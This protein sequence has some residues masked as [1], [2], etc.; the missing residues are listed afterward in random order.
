DQVAR[1]EWC[2]AVGEGQGQGHGG[3][4]RHDPAQADPGNQEEG[5]PGGNGIALAQAGAEPA[6]N[7]GGGE[8]P[9][10]SKGDDGGSDEGGI[11]D[12]LRQG[13]AE[14]SQPK[15][16]QG[17]LKS[18]EDEHDAVEQEDQCLPDAVEAQALLRSQDPGDVA[19]HVDAG[20]DGRENAGGADPFGREV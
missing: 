15:E 5:S 12:Q 1:D 11:A 19:A 20:G 10:D 13:V 7:I 16:D 9:D 18:D 6:W 4:K 17:Q 14:V 2:D 3:G 8:Y